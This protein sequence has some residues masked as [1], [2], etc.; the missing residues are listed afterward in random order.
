MFLNLVKCASKKKS[1][2]SKS[3]LIFFSSFSACCDFSNF[4][5][6]NLIKD[7][8][9]IWEQCCCMVSISPTFYKQLLAP[10]SLRK[11]IT[12][13]NCKH[14]KAAQ[15]NFSKKLLIKCWRNWHQVSISPTFYE[16][17]LAP[18]SFQKK[19]TNPNCK[20]TKAARKTF[21]QKSYS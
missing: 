2:E 1:K 18:K 19:I 6:F 11:K 8:K 13:P 7:T 14:T 16:Q 21:I 12:N 20:H 17:L 4:A 10:K 9:H 15:K 3:V 5:I